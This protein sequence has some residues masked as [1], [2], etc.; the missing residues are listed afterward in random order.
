MSD[1]TPKPI[2]LERVW[3]YRRVNKMIQARHW[4]GRGL[5]GAVCDRMQTRFPRACAFIPSTRRG[6]HYLSLI[7][8]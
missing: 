3:D 2:D 1:K 5:Y 7:H 8:I 4:S 6:A